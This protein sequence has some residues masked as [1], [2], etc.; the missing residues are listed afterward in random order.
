MRRGQTGLWVWEEGSRGSALPAVASGL[1]LR[2]R[3]VPGT[4]ALLTWLGA[5]SHPSRGPRR[6]VVVRAAPEG[7]VWGSPPRGRIPAVSG[8]L[9]G[10]RCLGSVTCSSTPLAMSPAGAPGCLWERVGHRPASCRRT[11]SLG[12]P[13]WP[14]GKLAVNSGDKHFQRTS[15]LLDEVG[16]TKEKGV[17]WPE[18]NVSHTRTHMCK[19]AHTHTHARSGTWKPPIFRGEENRRQ[20]RLAG[21]GPDPQDTV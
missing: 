19:R 9:Q 2:P 11:G 13:L 15:P 14:W 16:G 3:L 5:G 18:S 7:R 21:V 17:R 6:E 20:P 4:L 10:S 8:T 1:V 12:T